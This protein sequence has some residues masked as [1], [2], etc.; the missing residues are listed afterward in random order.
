MWGRGGSGWQLALMYGH[1]H[2]RHCCYTTLY[3]AAFMGHVKVV[4]ALVAPGGMCW[5]RLPQ[6]T[7]ISLQ[8][9]DEVTD[10]IVAPFYTNFEVLVAL[11]A[12][13]ADVDNAKTDNGDTTMS[14]AHC[15]LGAP[16]RQILTH[17]H[18]WHGRLHG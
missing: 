2:G 7:A 1:S 4:A 15:H 10:F 13:K 11:P 16:M 12:A 9:P 14:C 8:L 6:T 5:A 17:A 18:H 3:K